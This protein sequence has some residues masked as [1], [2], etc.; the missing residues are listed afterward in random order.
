MTLLKGRTSGPNALSSQEEMHV[1]HPLKERHEGA[2]AGPEMSN[3]AGE[4]SGDEVL[5]RMPEGTGVV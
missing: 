5:W 1:R 4:G 3:K 2:G